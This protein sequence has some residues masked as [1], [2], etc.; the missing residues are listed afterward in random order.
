MNDL[1]KSINLRLNNPFIFSFII[2][3]IFWN[4]PIVVG[5]LWYNA[6]TLQQY[7]Y[8]YSKQV[9]LHIHIQTEETKFVG[10]VYGENLFFFGSLKWNDNYTIL[11]G[12]DH[13]TF[14]EK[15]FDMRK[16]S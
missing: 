1:L 15:T 8:P 11:M 14:N 9:A 7:G 6:T 12:T 5:L 16:I 3:W 10:E 13:I 4:W 2:S